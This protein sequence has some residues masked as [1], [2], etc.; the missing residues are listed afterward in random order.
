M[1]SAEKV[2]DVEVNQKSIP[3]GEKGRGDEKLQLGAMPKHMLNIAKKARSTI[4]E[5]DSTVN[6][7]L[8]HIRTT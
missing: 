6:N 4:K 1:D 3:Q 8:N 7:H 5:L 2:L